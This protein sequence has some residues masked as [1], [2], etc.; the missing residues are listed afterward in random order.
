MYKL[1]KIIPISGNYAQ[2]YRVR[3]KQSVISSKA[4]EKRSLFLLEESANTL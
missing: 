1:I 4:Q 2:K 3:K